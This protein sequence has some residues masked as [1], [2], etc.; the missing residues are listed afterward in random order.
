MNSTNSSLYLAAQELWNKYLESGPGSLTKDAL[1]EFEN[2]KHSALSRP[3]L[4]SKVLEVI[5]QLDPLL[6]RCVER[7]EGLCFVTGEAGLI[8]N[9][10]LH[11]ECEQLISQLGN[12]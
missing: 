7:P 10:K 5:D 1:V 8:P 2:A 11:K 12:L 6:R 4:N 9:R 3:G